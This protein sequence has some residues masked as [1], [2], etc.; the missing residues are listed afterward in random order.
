MI[1]PK[2]TMLRIVVL[3]VLQAL[4]AT[5]CHAQAPGGPL[6]KE[7]VSKQKDIYESKGEEVPAGY[8]TGR[9]LLSYAFILPAAFKRSL[10]SLRANDR[11]LDIGAGEGRAILDYYA[12]KYDV[13][14]EGLDREA[15]KGKAVA[16]SIED[17]RT[18]EWHRMAESLE[19]N[20]IQYLF[21]KR[22][23]EYPPEALG[24]FQVMTDVL[25]AFSY[26]RYLSVFMEKALGLL[27]LNGSLYTLLQDVHAENGT[28][29]PFYPGASYLTEIVK[30]DG[31][32]VRICAWLKSIGCVQVTC[33]ARADWTPP[34]EVYHVQKVCEKVT[35]PGLVAIHF[36]AGTPPERRF[37][38]TDPSEPLPTA[39][40][41]AR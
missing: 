41:T 6:F 32:E 23:R 14:L 36:E 24:K 18:A 8:V 1:R 10:G 37:R 7:E 12:S 38:L 5:P 16:I 9:S 30:A 17:R 35:V 11:W 33:E 29:R 13:M 34:V 15:R 4:W 3:L 25:G 26:T 40:G 22:L 27:T 2:I 28:N 21:G 39:P 19:P 31:S 20:Q